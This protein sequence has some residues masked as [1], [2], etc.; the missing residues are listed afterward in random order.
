[1]NNSIVFSS[2]LSEGDDHFQAIADLTGSESV[3][4][5]YVCDIDD[6]RL[7]R[8]AGHRSLSKSQ[9]ALFSFSV[10]F[11]NLIATQPTKH[12]DNISICSPLTSC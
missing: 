1:M 10:N 6:T 2:A 3:T 9:S 7:V 12:P 11:R 4:A 8:V 5:V